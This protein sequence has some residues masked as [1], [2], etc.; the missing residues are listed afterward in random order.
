MYYLRAVL[1]RKFAKVCAKRSHH[2]VGDPTT[3]SG[4]SL[5][6]HRVAAHSSTAVDD[7]GDSHGQATRRL[8]L[9]PLLLQRACIITFHPPGL[10]RRRHHPS[11][12]RLTPS[13]SAIVARNAHNMP[14]RSGQLQRSGGLNRTP[15]FLVPFQRV[16]LWRRG[17]SL[18]TCVLVA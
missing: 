16:V 18:S 11:L 12:S 7:L 2:T 3:T 6:G 9:D 13:C 14:G 17:W 8:P 5:A 1:R 4:T 10:D 15:P